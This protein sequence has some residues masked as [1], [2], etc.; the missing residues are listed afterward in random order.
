MTDIDEYSIR[1]A[2]NVCQMAGDFDYVSNARRELRKAGILDAVRSHDTATIFDWLLRNVSLQGVSDRTA[3]TYLKL[4]GS[5]AW[6]AIGRTIRTSNRCPKLR[7]HWHFFDCGYVKNQHRC[8]CMQHLQRCPLPRHDLRNGRL[9][10][11]AYSLFFFIRD[12]ANGDLVA[13]I[14]RRLESK[15]ADAA[16]LSAT[17]IQPLRSVFGVSDKVLN[18]SLSTL[19][20][21]G[22]PRSSHWFAAG[23][24]MIAIDSLVHNFLHRTGISHRCDREHLYGAQC[25]ASGGCISIVEE[26]SRRIDARKFNSAFPSYFPRFVQHSLWRYCAQDELNVCNGIRVRDG[27]RCR[28]DWCRLYGHCDRVVLRSR[29]QN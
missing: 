26:L 28:N 14:D 24:R 23:T 20:V 13:W 11:T 16:E 22:R 1:L 10:Q 21:G 7:D 12:V 6:S 17:L 2:H 27:G 18:M 9:N 19:L 25:Y 8:N 3:L 4:H 29:R 5:P 15:V